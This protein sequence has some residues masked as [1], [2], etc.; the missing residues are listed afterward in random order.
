MNESNKPGIGFWIV[1][2][3]ALLWMA[4]GCFMYLTQAF[5]MAM[6][7]EGLNEDQIALMESLPAWSTALFAIAVFGGLL[8]A[9]LFLMKKKLSAMLFIV[10]FLAALIDQIHWLFM[11]DAPEVFS[12]QNPYM[13]PV[14]IIVLGLF[15]VWYSKKQKEDGVLT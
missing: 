12:D 1:G 13:M 7:T 15:F 6:A 3:I 8:A 4:W 10:S 9:I 2:I 11:T 5:D 14:I